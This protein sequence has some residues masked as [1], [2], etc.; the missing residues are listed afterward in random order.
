MMFSDVIK[1]VS[2]VKTSDEYG[3][4]Q[5]AY[6]ERT[7]Y[8]TLKSISQAEFYQAQAVGLK[9]EIKFIL[10]DW[11]DY[12]GEKIV[13]YTPYGSSEEYQYEILR[14][15]RDGYSLELTCVRGIDSN[16]VESESESQ[17]ESDSVTESESGSELGSESLEEGDGA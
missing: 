8:A 6:T 7:V 11:L 13:R 16:P 1:L 15:F 10:A 12:N 9:P 14:T 4:M 5:I 17:S 2:E 3:D